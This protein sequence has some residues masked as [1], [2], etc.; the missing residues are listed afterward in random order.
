[1]DAT[2]DR[3][4][5]TNSIVPTTNVSG[6][7]LAGDLTLNTGTD[8]NPVM[9]TFRRGITF[10]DVEVAKLLLG[11][12][13]DTFT[14]NA[15]MTPPDGTAGALTIIE[16]GGN[17][18]PTAG[19]HIIVNG[20][21]GPT[22][23]LVVYGDTSQNGLD[24]AGTSG[25]PSIHGISFDFSGNDVIDARND[26]NGVTIYG[27]AGDDTI[28][29]SQAGDRIAGG[30]GND[31]IYGEGG[32][33]LIYG[34]NGI[35]VDESK[36]NFRA[37]SVPFGDA[38][39]FDPDPLVQHFISAP[40][41]DA[42]TAP[43]RDLIRGG[44][45]NDMLDGG[46]GND[47]IFGDNVQLDRTATL[48]NFANP[49]FRD[50][51]GTQ[52]YSTTAATMGQA[53]VDGGPQRD[54]LGSPW[55]GDFQITMFDLASSDPTLF[56]NDYIAGGPGNDTIFGENGNDVIQG[57]GSIDFRPAGQ[58]P[59]S[60]SIGLVG[61]AQIDSTTL[62][63]AVRDANNALRLNA[64]FD[65][66]TDGNDYI[67]GGAGNDVIFGNQGQDDIVGG[68]S[69]LFSQTTKAQ[70][71]DGSNI[72]FG[73]S[74]TMVGLNDAGNTSANG[75]AHD[76]DAIVANNGDIF[77]LV[78]TNGV[79]GQGAGP[80]GFLQFNYDVF[81]N[82]S[83]TERIVPRAVTL[84]DYTP[85]GPD[86]AG[87]AGPLVPGDVGGTLVN[88]VLKGSEI[89]GEAGNDFIYGGPG[90]DVMFGDGQNDSIV[91]GYGADWI[92]GGSG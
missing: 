55:W 70:R 65:A 42:L 18:S 89:H 34:D 25:M 5:I 57:D 86:Y 73:G 64:S 36:A 19:D 79:A 62:V 76:A 44:T 17:T 47:L 82:P 35:N 50:L 16:G 28:R 63:G 59:P 49:R 1:M 72:I 54:P 67:E 56:G 52:I 23:P 9:T 33:D 8:S 66:S 15:T 40:N 3:D 90:N 68:S 80:N 2:S 32:N 45:G 6:L 51:T 26:Q 78:G 29:G 37:L 81:G 75:Q 58:L 71:Q 39:V 24:Y 87:T 92:S 14:V 69:D 30:S 4:P 43:G 21:G 61:A 60:A 12:G 38:P 48:G 91:G 22:S 46:A 74:G 41:R 83:A 88:G 77:R 10:K 7:G 20:G 31:A 84:L 53:L 85:G 11:Q 27:G 13:D